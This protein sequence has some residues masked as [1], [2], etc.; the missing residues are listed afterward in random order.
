MMT[1]G[2]ANSS[3][4]EYTN[5]AII[6]DLKRNM[7]SRPK[8]IKNEVF[9]AIAPSRRALRWDTST[10]EL[11]T[12]VSG[13]AWRR[14][15]FG[16]DDDCPDGAVVGGVGGVWCA[17]DCC[18]GDGVPVDGG[19]GPT[20][21]LGPGGGFGPGGG[22]PVGDC[23]PGVRFAVAGTEQLSSTRRR[24]AVVGGTPGVRAGFE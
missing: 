16:A 17:G 1:T 19:L 3:S 13:K 12:P 5:A 2:T 18:A 20:G 10:D 23:G 11:T 4:A 6:P 21:G 7:T 9:N 8:K 15:V 14:W 22:A 24:F